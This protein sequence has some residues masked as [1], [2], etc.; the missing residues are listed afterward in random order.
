M[1]RSLG[2]P[3][4][5][6]R[7]GSGRSPLK[8]VLVRGADVLRSH[9]DGLAPAAGMVVLGIGVLTMPAWL[10]ATGFLTL[11]DGVLAG[12]Y[13]LLG[14]GMVLLLGYTGQLALTVN[15]SYGIGAYA[16]AILTVDDRIDPWLAMLVGIVVN[17]VVALALAFPLFR[18]Q[19]HFLAVAT[20]GVALMGYT[21]FEAA[22]VTGGANGI[23]GIPTL[24]IGSF[25]FVSDMAW[26]YLV[27]V[28]ALAALLACRNLVTSHFGRAMLAVS[29]SEAAAESSGARP[30]WIKTLVFVVAAALSSVAGSLY[31]SYAGFVSSSSFDLTLTLTLLVMVVV[32]GLRSLWALPFGV[33]GILALSAALQTYGPSVIPATGSDIPIVGYGVILILFLLVVPGGLASAGRWCAGQA[34]RLVA[35][36]AA[37]PA[38]QPAGG[39]YGT[40]SSESRP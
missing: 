24:S 30:F 5:T 32:G 28:I 22:P 17:I 39:L 27:W 21:V 25:H 35:R 18:L 23:N 36:V 2:A 1:T 13:T 15:A 3:E 8:K 9:R 10:P 37:T 16:T 40:A 38:T 11:T 14:I 7:D 31:A 4:G 6:A 26:T 34:G 33:L 20:L 29:G 12:I 19:G